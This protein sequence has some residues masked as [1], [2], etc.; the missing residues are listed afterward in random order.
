MLIEI[1][2]IPLDKME[3]FSPRLGIA[4][5]YLAYYLMWLKEQRKEKLDKLNKIN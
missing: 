3:S 2:P 1:T 5:R 4:K